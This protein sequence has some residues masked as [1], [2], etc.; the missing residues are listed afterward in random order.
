MIIEEEK[1]I[2]K[3][4]EFPIKIPMIILSYPLHPI[5]LMVVYIIIYKKFN[6]DKKLLIYFLFCEL[7]LHLIKYYVGRLRP[8]Q[9]NNEI[10]N[11]DIINSRSASFPSGHSFG[12]WFIGYYYLYVKFG[13][14][15]WYIVPLLVGLS[16]M[17]LGVHYPSDVVMGFIFAQLSI[18]LA[19]YFKILD[20]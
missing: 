15:Q 9:N 8:Y 13:F 20:Q 1:F 6:Q 7:L 18:E 5:V 3:L 19:Y 11:L 17:A 2:K 4:Q 16:R 10:N 14:K 12:A